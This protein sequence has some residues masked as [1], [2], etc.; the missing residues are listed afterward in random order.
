MIMIDEKN[1]GEFLGQDLV[2]QLKV[3]GQF[4]FLFVQIDVGGVEFIGDGGF[5]FVLVKVVF[6]WGLQVELISYL[7]YEKGL[8]EVLKYVNFCNGIIL[9]IVEFEVGLIELDVL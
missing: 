6:E 4:D 1:L 3:L 2:E 9:K 5:V 8:S 7:G